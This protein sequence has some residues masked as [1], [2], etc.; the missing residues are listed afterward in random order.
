MK[1]NSSMYENDNNCF[2]EKLQVADDINW[3]EERVISWMTTKF[4]QA[5]HKR[6]SGTPGAEQIL[7]IVNNLRRNGKSPGPSL[8]TTHEDG[9]YANIYESEEAC[10]TAIGED[11][12]RVLKA[13]QMKKVLKNATEFT[14]AK[15]QYIQLLQ[16]HLGDTMTARLYAN[17]EFE[18]QT[19]I[20]QNEKKSPAKFYALIT[21]VA[22]QTILGTDEVSKTTRK[23]NMHFVFESIKQQPTEELATFIRRYKIGYNSIND[24]YSEKEQVH[25]VI[26]RMYHT[27]LHLLCQKLIVPYPTTLDALLAMAPK[28]KSSTVSK[29]RANEHVFMSGEKPAAAAAPTKRTVPTPGKDKNSGRYEK[30]DSDVWKLMTEDQRDDFRTL[31]RAQFK[32]DR[33][34]KGDVALITT[35]GEY[36]QADQADWEVAGE[37]I[38]MMTRGGDS[39]DSVYISDH[40]N[41]PTNPYDYPRDSLPNERGSLYNERCQPG[42]LGAAGGAARFSNYDSE[43]HL[44]PIEA[45]TARGTTNMD[46]LTLYYAVVYA[47]T[48]DRP[49]PYAVV[50]SCESWSWVRQYID[51]VTGVQHWRAKSQSL[52]IERITHCRSQN[53][54]LNGTIDDPIDEV[55]QH[56]DYRPS[57]WTTW[58]AERTGHCTPSRTNSAATRSTSCSKFFMVTIIAIVWAMMTSLAHGFRQSMIRLPSTATQYVRQHPQETST[59]QDVERILATSTGDTPFKSTHVVFDN[60]STIHVCKNKLLSVKPKRCERRYI[61]G[62]NDGEEHALSYDQRCQFLSPL[63]GDIPMCEGAAANIISQGLSKDQGFHVDYTDDTDKYVLTHPSDPG[64]RFEF[65]RVTV[66]G[67]KLR[68]Y[69]MDASTMR[70]PDYRIPFQIVLGPTQSMLNTTVRDNAAKY[71]I[72]QV[73]DAQ[74]ALAFLDGMGGPPLQAAVAQLSSMKNP[75]VAP[76]DI[77]RAIDIY[78]VPTPDTKSRT[79]RFAVNPSKE[80]RAPIPVQVEQTMQVDLFFVK[81]RPFLCGILLPLD[82]AYVVPLADKSATTLAAALSE[83]ISSSSA[84][85]FVIRYLRCD[86]EK[87]IKSPSTV[88]DIQ[89]KGVELD[90]C[91]AGEHCPEVERRIRWIKEKYRRL[92]Q[93]LPYTMTSTLMDWAVRAAGR[94]TNLQRTSSSNSRSS[95]RDKYLGRPFDYSVD[96]R[97]SF[98]TYIQC[99]A[100]ATDNTPTPRTQGCIALMPTDNM[101]GTIYCYHILTG[102]IITRDQFVIVPTPDALIDRIDS[103]ASKQGYTRGVE[104]FDVNEWEAPQDILAAENEEHLPAEPTFIPAER[105][106][107]D[108]TIVNQPEE[109]T[110]IPADTRVAIDAAVDQTMPDNP[111]TRQIRPPTDQGD[112]TLAPDV[113]TDAVAAH[114]DIDAIDP[115]RRTSGRRTMQNVTLQDA[116]Y[117][118]RGG[119]RITEQPSVTMTTFDIALARNMI[120]RKDWRDKD[121]A[122]ITSV[123]AALREHGDAAG[124]VIEQELTQFVEKKVFH[125][126]LMKGL[127]REQRHRIL[128]SKMFLKEKYLPSGMFE[129]LK[130]RLVAGGH[131]QDRSL[132]RDEDTSSPTVAHS[133]VMS[134][135]AI[136]ACEGRQVAVCDIGGA[137]LNAHM[138]ADGVKVL[139]RIDA[140]LSAILAKLFPAQYTP[141]LTDKGELVVELDRAMYGCVEAAKL[142]F[143]TLRSTLLGMG[144]V[145]NEYDE[146]VFNRTTGKGP[147]CTIVLHVDDMLITCSDTSVISNV[148]ADILA[149]YPD[150]KYQL[151]PK[152]PYLGMDLD[153][154]VPGEVRITMDGMVDDI[155]AKS[156]VTLEPALTPATETL[157]NVSHMCPPA[158][159]E[160]ADWFHQN[161]AKLL[162]LCKRVRPECLTTVAFLATRVTKTDQEDLGKLRR[163][164]RYISC[165]R[166]RGL[167]LRPG[168]LGI[169]VRAYIDAAYGVHQ[170]CKSHTGCAIVIGDAGPTFVLSGKQSIVTKSSTEAEV[171]ATSDSSSQAFHVRNFVIAQGHD[172]KPAMILQDNLSC[173]ALIRKGKST[174]M[175]TRHIKIRYFWVTDRLKQGEGVMM[176]V[177]TEDM[178]PANILT[179]PLQ[180]GQ[181]L[182]ERQALTNWD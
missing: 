175:R 89:D 76:S 21:R 32:S 180:G 176:H 120:H 129:K 98:G 72:R 91:G 60:A 77:R 97:V 48:R 47:S 63:L 17:S 141:F 93:R 179:K 69:I 167:C 124:T 20:L 116:I 133:S 160:E 88:K 182:K 81:L 164:L 80:E 126:V 55:D 118:E 169:Q 43:P 119:S 140:T 31:R 146:C 16:A 54:T 46:V 165:T 25:D 163:V 39:E 67:R 168:S 56:D 143:D 158:T 114:L 135:C 137:F 83:W 26:R 14:S 172:D 52:A 117:A 90:F 40:R 4:P 152:V 128:P 174:A 127:T 113:P 108:D 1:P 12:F 153:F 103:L 95:P 2:V 6:L 58:N 104:P 22:L 53:P 66:R 171:V 138:P 151:G 181:F 71:T 144:F 100:R 105:G 139:V 10:K 170:D 50:Y 156:G 9:P 162:Y 157:F 7:G 70:S 34:K 59:T 86:N 131:R 24:E 155:I 125:P 115:P 27:E 74:K 178:G 78:G 37:E 121:F 18:N 23:L 161:T 85:G 68:H 112:R 99:T 159:K 84:R 75:P 110:L 111:V 142:W 107:A 147:Q 3:T 82:Y 38:I 42:P 101:T 61:I 96:A 109:I 57:S 130:A 173:M 11:A 36:D 132:Y 148:L 30:V 166:G 8:T 92:E 122:F 51:G 102:R 73:A 45:P 28:Y 177:S 134:V 33:Q 13:E 65:G 49:C 123:K 87:G 79:V 19:L 154:S 64:L 44:T 41:S 5:M 150:T 62:I 145:Q 106:V 136:A 29:G 15:G 94:F 149:I 35:S